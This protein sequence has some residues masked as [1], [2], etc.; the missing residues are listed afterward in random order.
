VG[1]KLANSWGLYDMAGNVEEWCHD[2]YQFAQGTTLLINPVGMDSGPGRA[3]RGGDFTLP[4]KTLRAAFRRDGFATGRYINDGFRCGRTIFENSPNEAPMAQGDTALTIINAGVDIEVLANDEDADG[5]EVIVLSVGAAAHGTASQNAT[6]RVH[7]QPMKDHAGSDAFTYEISDGKGGKGSATVTVI[8]ENKINGKPMAQEDTAKT[9]QNTAIEINVLSN[10]LDAEGDAL[11]VSGVGLASYGTATKTAMGTVQYQPQA[12]YSGTDSFIYTVSDTK[13][14]SAL[15]LVT[16]TIAPEGVPGTW[17]PIPKGTFSMGSPMGEPGRQTNETQHLVTLS[18]DFEI[19]STEVTQGLFAALMGFNPSE[20]KAC[21]NDCPVEKVSWHMA[22]AYCNALSEQMGYAPCYSCSGSG[23]SASCHESAAF[24]GKQIY[25]CP[26]YRLPTEAEWEYAYRAKTATAYYDG[27]KE[28]HVLGCQEDAK[29]NALGWYCGNSMVSY[30]GCEDGS[31]TGD[32]SC[33]GPH[34]V[35][36]KLPNVW[37]LYD[38]TGN[39]WEWCHDG[40]LKNLGTAALTDPVGPSSTEGV[41]RGGSWNLTALNLRGAYR[42]SISR[43]IR[44]ND[45]G[46]RCARSL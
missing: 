38:M 46:F 40:Y 17:E 23:S 8:I 7:Y 30:W 32:P 22:A 15:G 13:G 24:N 1:K 44:W 26:G 9:A 45:I 25:A 43:T 20:F 37:G 35:G 4:P 5:D 41:I 16:V 36:K 3:L 11:A 42:W 31:E 21:G 39:V 6:G 10:D 18:H 19:M 34:P 29:I 2:G 28:P 12:D 14:G 27:L 33:Y